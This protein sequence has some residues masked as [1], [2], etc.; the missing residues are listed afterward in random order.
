MIMIDKMAY[1]SNLRYVNP[2]LKCFF[3]FTT[4]IICLIDSSILVS[5]ITILTMVG[6]TLIFNKTPVTYYLKIM[7]IPLAFI[8]LSTITIIINVTSIPLDLFA[9]NVGKFYLSI[10]LKSLFL[11]VNLILK[12]IACIS[13]LYF[14]ALSTTFTDIL[15][16]LKNIHCPN[17]LI[18]LMLLIYRF[19]FVLLDIAHNITLSQNS[20]LGNKDFKTSLKSM[21]E[22]LSVL[23]VKSLKKASAL[24]DSMES[25]CYNDNINV[26]FEC[27]K[28]STRS[29]I[30]VI[31][32]ETFIL[33]I[34]LFISN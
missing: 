4:L 20:S 28:A 29:I 17:I 8:L 19:I 9:I 3:A 27:S 25:R 7:T 30:L 5:S 34:S 11:G 12:S 21:A 2:N 14:L 23:L 18:E 24:Y 6:I 15:L 13:C 26:L 1:T 10:S 32:F 31:L 22:L 16:V 33:I